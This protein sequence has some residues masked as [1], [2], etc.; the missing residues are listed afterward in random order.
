MSKDEDQLVGLQHQYC[1]QSLMHDGRL[2]NQF[3]LNLGIGVLHHMNVGGN[4]NE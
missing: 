2:M 1:L 3:C 4:N